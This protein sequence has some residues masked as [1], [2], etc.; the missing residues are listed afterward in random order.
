MIAEPHI[1]DKSASTSQNETITENIFIILEW[2]Q[3]LQKKLRL[4]CN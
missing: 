3:D 2:N 4:T 1:C